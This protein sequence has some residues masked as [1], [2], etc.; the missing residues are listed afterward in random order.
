MN[1][2][3]VIISEHYRIPL[4]VV[5]TN[6][7]YTYKLVSSRCSD[8]CVPGGFS[9]SRGDWITKISAVT[10]PFML[11]VSQNRSEQNHKKCRRYSVSKNRKNEPFFQW[12]VSFQGLGIFFELFWTGKLLVCRFQKGMGL[13]WSNL[14]QSVEIYFS[15]STCQKYLH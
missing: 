7:L 15:A 9:G 10:K 1:S 4:W 3:V 5:F 6:T 11:W 8:F 14:L 2:I 12:S 13:I